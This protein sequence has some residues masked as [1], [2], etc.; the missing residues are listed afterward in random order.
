MY[1]YTHIYTLIVMSL[2]DHISIIESRLPDIRT[3]ELTQMC[4]VTDWY[5]CRDPLTCVP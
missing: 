4:A 1:T 3:H 2:V 5:V